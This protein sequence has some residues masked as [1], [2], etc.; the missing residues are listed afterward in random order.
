MRPS[1]DVHYSA[2]RRDCKARFLR[3]RKKRIAIISFDRQSIGKDLR[4]NKL[5]KGCVALSPPPLGEGG[6]KGPGGAAFFPPLSLRD[7]S[8]RSGGR[9]GALYLF[10]YIYFSAVPKQDA[11]SDKIKN[12]G[13]KDGNAHAAAV[14]KSSAAANAQPLTREISIAESV[15]FSKEKVI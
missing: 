10:S 13:A 2:F 12:F 8:P 4:K 14:R 1:G 7:I 11:Q 6:P 9:L 5:L 15:L 3:R